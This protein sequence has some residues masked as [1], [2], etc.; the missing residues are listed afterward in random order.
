MGFTIREL[1]E[2]LQ[3]QREG[4]HKFAYLTMENNRF[5]CFAHAFFIFVHF[6]FV[7]VLATMQNDL[8][9]KCVDKVNNQNVSFSVFFFCCFFQDSYIYRQV[10]S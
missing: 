6:A 10:E 3:Q 2:P 1:K 9:C 7:L 5:T 8:F 4:H